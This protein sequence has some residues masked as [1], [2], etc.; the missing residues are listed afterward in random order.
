MLSCFKVLRVWWGR[1]GVRDGITM[2]GICV[3]QSSVSSRG[4]SGSAL[5]GS[6]LRLG[7]GEDQENFSS[8]SPAR[9]ELLV[10]EERTEQSPN[11]PSLTSWSHLFSHSPHPCP[12]AWFRMSPS[13]TPRDWIIICLKSRPCENH[14]SNHY[15]AI[16]KKML[17]Q[18]PAAGWGFSYDALPPTSKRSGAD[19]VIN[20]AV[21]AIPKKR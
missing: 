6:Q 16:K 11:L 3:P 14:P 9:M 4:C 10:V 17:P 7:A 5:Q 1:R 12:F 19:E 13:S 18:L 15:A 2:K 21:L 20:V 8:D